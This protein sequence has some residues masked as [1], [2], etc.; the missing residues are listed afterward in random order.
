[1]SPGWASLKNRNLQSLTIALM[2]LLIS[3][4][5]Y[6]ADQRNKQSLRSHVEQYTYEEAQYL[7]GNINDRLIFII[8]DLYTVYR[9]EIPQSQEMH[10]ARTKH[11]VDANPFL[12]SIN[13]ISKARRIQYVSPL[14]PNRMVI[15]LKI[16]ITAPKKAMELAHATNK[17]QLSRPF[18]MVQGQAGYSLMI[19]HAD[20]G[21]FELVFKAESIFGPSSAFRYHKSIIIKVID[22]GE[23]VFADVEFTLD[24]SFQRTSSDKILAHNFQLYAS[25]SEKFI[26]ETT[27]FW[28]ILSVG[29]LFSS[30][31]LLV[32]MVVFQHFNLRDRSR[33]VE[34]MKQKA[35]H[36][37][38]AQRLARMG[39]WSR[40]FIKDQLVWSEG[41]LAIFQ[42]E[43]KDD[44][45]FERFL[46]FVHPNDLT[47]LK[48]AYETCFKTGN[49]L[50]IRYRIICPDQSIRY[51]HERGEVILDGQGKALNASGTVQDLTESYEIERALR[52]ERDFN[53]SLIE[54]AQVIILVLDVEGQIVTFNPHLSE[55]TGYALEEV[56]GKSWFD[57]FLPNINKEEIKTLFKHAVGDTQTRGNVNSIKTRDGSFVD[58]EWYD[59]TLKDVDGQVTGLLAIGLDITQRQ[60]IQKEHDLNEQRLN[61]L[62]TLNQTALDLSEREICDQALDIA[63]ELTSSE[64]GYLHMIEDDQ[65]TISL[66]TWHER[67]KQECQTPQEQ[68]QYPLEE[69]GL[70]ADCIREKR[71]VIHNDYQEMDNKHGMLEGYFPIQRHMSTPVFDR[72]KVSLVIGVGN[73]AAPYDEYDV[74]Q[75]QLIATEVQKIVMRQRAEVALRQAKEDAEIA[76]QAKGDF[77]ATMSHEIRTPMNLVVGMGDVLLDS[78]LN[79]EQQHHVRKL[80]EAGNTL[81][82]L[83]ND[84]LDFSK[85]ES[86]KLVLRQEP[87]LT[88]ELVEGCLD[89]LRPLAEEKGLSVRFEMETGVPT[90]F[91]GDEGR[92]KQVLFNLISNAIKFTFEGS[93]TIILTMSQGMPQSLCFTI[94]DTGIGINTDEFEEIFE[95]FSQL[96]QGI[97]R[98]YGGTGLGLAISRQ[99][100]QLWGGQIEV[101]SVQGE[102]STFTFTHPSITPKKQINRLDTADIQPSGSTDQCKGL[103]ILMVEDA[104]DNQYLIQA[105]LKKTDHQ[106]DMANNGLEA[107]DAWKSCPYDLILMDIQMP[108]M[109]GYTATRSIRKLEIQQ[110][111]KRTP[112]VALTAHA[113]DGDAE[114]SLDAGCDAH[115]TKPIKKTALLA[116]IQN[117]GCQA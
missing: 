55:L 87:I 84:I 29:T 95:K 113:L 11:L 56:V 107:I 88:R 18:E 24:D 79:D 62:L 34:E 72:G 3:G 111:R 35:A 110:Q 104:V 40:D 81:L 109:D 105:F 59:R 49:P 112:I 76:S 115:L 30:I 27:L 32:A 117:Y 60:Q 20:G 69:A 114:K 96:D 42:W 19:P 100:V 86:G 46:S 8:D 57:I 98:K 106:L 92:I 39:S 66:L 50:D 33:I 101:S 23:A 5:F 94:K 4:V 51:L 83:I 82:D 93:V 41:T 64:V 38:E 102:G 97:S 80:Q 71:T 52:Q 25:A 75:L 12:Q 116:A 67:A 44:L 108:Q 77:L 31:V 13:Y 21:F 85:L 89:V 48:Q 45:T 65:N 74:K 63:V 37:K 47:P 68:H 70:W 78:P 90:R 36:L 17:P 10:S 22:D 7:F 16:G 6:Y 43:N 61:L 73:K 99:V 1:M 9:T 14:E 26:A 2:I 103:R 58:V 15:G 91:V 28:K 53:N 54:T